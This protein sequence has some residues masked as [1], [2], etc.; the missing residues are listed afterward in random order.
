M[1]RLVGIAGFILASG[2]TVGANAATVTYDV[3]FSANNFTSAYGQAAPADPVTGSFRIT[4]DPTQTYTDDTSHITL[5][6]LNIALGSA[7]SFDYSPTDNPNG[8]AGELVVGGV[9]DGAASV[10]Y[11]PPTD[12]FWLHIYTVVTSPTFQQVGYSQTSLS[13]D[14]LF[15]TSGVLGEDGSVTVTLVTPGVPEPSTWA[16]MAAGF[17]A[18]GWVGHSRRGSRRA[19]AA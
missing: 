18:L 11:A 14:N 17:A 13:S 1:R 15:Y 8:F 9:A 12:D 2:I 10:Q 3:T 19:A 4:F 5:K 7:L 16:M 6:T